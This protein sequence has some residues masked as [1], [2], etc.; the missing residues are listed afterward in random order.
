MQRLGSQEFRW[1]HAVLTW[2][3]VLSPVSASRL[4][5]ETS[6]ASNRGA[7]RGARGKTW[8]TTIPEEAAMPVETTLP[9]NTAMPTEP[10]VPTGPQ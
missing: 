6:D 7:R 9:V 4:R 5:V 8:V 10:K 2:L 3:V 1:L